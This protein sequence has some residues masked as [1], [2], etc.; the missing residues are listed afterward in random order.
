MGMNSNVFLSVT[1]FT[2]EAKSKVKSIDLSEY[3]LDGWEDDEDN[4]L[5]CRTEDLAYG[6]NDFRDLMEKI[7]DAI[8]K[9]GKAYLAELC[10]EDVPEG[11][12][13]FYIGGKVRYKKFSE[14]DFEDF[15]ETYE[16][17][18]V[19]DDIF[20][21]LLVWDP[22][23]IVYDDGEVNFIKKEKE[24]LEQDEYEEE[25]DPD[26]EDDDESNEEEGEFGYCD[27]CGDET[28]NGT[29]LDSGSFVCE[30]CL[31]NCC[32]KCEECGK[33]FL[34]EAMGTYNGKRLCFIC[35][36]NLKSN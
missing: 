17:P 12:V 1:T 27:F 22:T 34:N 35:A 29:K 20:I 8:G 13:Y 15:E 4:E 32:E 5:Y 30:R 19:E 28:F 23:Y 7:K 14:Y 2:D 9:S 33:T 36:G 18:D 3:N 6:R 26:M 25:E 21:P 11:T 31:E 10:M 24:I 16:W